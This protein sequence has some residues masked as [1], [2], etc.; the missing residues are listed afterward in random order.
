MLSHIQDCE[1]YGSLREESRKSWDNA[2]SDELV[3]LNDP[4]K[5]ARDI[6][7]GV[8]G[9]IPKN[10]IKGNLWV[11]G[12]L[13]FVFEG[14]AEHLLF[15]IEF[16]NPKDIGCGVG[17]I[18]SYLLAMNRDSPVLV[19][20]A[21]SVKSRQQVERGIC[22]VIRLKRLDDAHCSCGY[23][24]RVLTELLPISNGIMIEDRKL[25][26]GGVSDAYLAFGQRP[27]GLVKR[28]S[29]TVEKISGDK[30][31][32]I[33]NLQN[34]KANSMASLLYIILGENTYRVGFKKSANLIPQGLQVYLRPLGLKVGVL[35]G[36]ACLLR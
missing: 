25:R 11:E 23:F 36:D 14:H 16:Y 13:T 18:K 8:H 24:R 29:E 12:H 28:G 22:S 7:R 17:K 19:D 15:S 4:L 31:D 5:I 20:V 33:G 1:D 10:Y 21:E 26:M 34:L 32:W 9:E 30:R 2:V 6:D 27:N 3:Y 35:Q